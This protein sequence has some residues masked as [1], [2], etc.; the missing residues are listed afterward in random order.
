MLSAGVEKA[1]VL[2]VLATAATTSSSSPA[3]GTG[4]PLSRWVVDA[5]TGDDDADGTSADRAFRTL[6]RARAAV[7]AAAADT[8]RT[9]CGGERRVV[10]REG[11]YAPLQLSAT[12]GG[13]VASPVVYVAWPGE[14]AVISA[15][16][17]VPSTAVHV[18]AHPS[19]RT[20]A[21][22]VLHVSLSRLGVGT[23]NYGRLRGDRDYEQISGEFGCA[24]RKME[25]HLDGGQVA[26]S[27]SLPL[28]KVW[29][30]P[31]STKYPYLQGIADDHPCMP[32]HNNISYDT[33]NTRP[34]SFVAGFTAC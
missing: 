26:E 15:G 14:R 8:D 30:P 10:L 25:V 9:R 22:A 7:A 17:H 28:A 5:K 3:A 27:V 16:Y 21:P 11:T 18:V 20:R 32:V 19:G 4:C 6:D 13:T 12:D 23:E 2:L 29:Q 24:N 31:W 1:V 34:A 33:I